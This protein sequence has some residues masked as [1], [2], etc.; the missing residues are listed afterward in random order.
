[1]ESNRR[2]NL[3]K[4]WT[5]AYFVEHGRDGRKLILSELVE[6]F[7][8][9]LD[10]LGFN[11][12]PQRRHQ[13][14]CPIS[15][16][17]TS[18]DH[19]NSVRCETIPEEESNGS[20]VGSGRRLVPNR[21][22]EGQDMFFHSTTSLVYGFA[23]FARMI[24][25]IGL[26]ITGWILEAQAGLKPSLLWVAC[27]YMTLFVEF[28]FC[29][30]SVAFFVLPT[31]SYMLPGL[32][33][34]LT[35]VLSTLI[36]AV[37]TSYLAYGLYNIIIVV[38]N[39]KFVQDFILYQSSMIS[40]PTS[41]QRRQ[42]VIIFVFFLVTAVLEEPLFT[43]LTL[44]DNDHAT[45][46]ILPTING[47]LISLVQYACFFAVFAGAAGISACNMLVPMLTTFVLVASEKHL[48]IVFNKH[49][50]CYK[51]AGDLNSEQC[52]L[53]SLLDER[54]RCVI[55]DY[56]CTTLAMDWP[57]LLL[58]DGDHH[59]HSLPATSPTRQ[60]KNR[61]LRLK[62]L[63][64]T[65]ANSRR[66]ARNDDSRW[67]YRATSTSLMF[68]FKNLTSN[69][70]E[71][72]QL[73]Q[74]F[75]SRFGLYHLLDNSI[76]SM[77]SA[78]LFM[79]GVIKYRLREEKAATLGT[80]SIHIGQPRDFSQSLSGN[81]GAIDETIGDYSIQ[82]GLSLWAATWTRLT[83]FDKHVALCLIVFFLSNTFVFFKCDC[84]PKFTDKMR[85]Q[86]FKL[87]IDLACLA[88]A[89]R[90][91]SGQRQQHHRKP[92]N[93]R[94]FL[95]LPSKSKLPLQ[96]LNHQQQQQVPRDNLTVFDRVGSANEWRELDEVWLLYDHLVR[97]SE[98]T[99]LRFTSG[100]YYSKRCLL[101]IFGRLVSLTLLLIQAI[102]MYL[103]TQ[104]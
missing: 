84:L 78:I 29:Y 40:L 66:N 69:L 102:N 14:R 11:L 39:R 32:N 34:S 52:H 30:I 71:L 44:I 63:S 79:G 64:K 50:A 55:S 97:I 95:Q 100:V 87:N 9:S 17:N 7:K 101:G 59:H 37:E 77:I 20:E 33:P 51:H 73:L 94:K 72:K 56:S 62:I 82:G 45:R 4:L 19:F 58:I 6:L 89:S 25:G 93:R 85:H 49:L 16:F 48:E 80:N 99:N 74:S 98:Q 23:L 26:W 22:S 57:Q 76:K 47:H 88:L 104:H 81:N 2:P 91:S 60:S 96:K 28:F 12:R 15:R 3:V 61:S 46:P 43:L 8:S 21:T 70:S 92:G 42:A 75:E 103:Y 53:I 13:S 86:L 67:R 68:L 10:G 38:G 27:S 5:F 36:Q 54:T 90:E 31:V 41:F 65:F 24:D 18:P 35:R 1:M 83:A